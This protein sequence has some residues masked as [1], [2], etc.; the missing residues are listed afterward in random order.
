MSNTDEQQKAFEE[1]QA[2]QNRTNKIHDSVKMQ[3][4]RL[5]TSAPIMIPQGYAIAGG[6]ALVAMIVATFPIL[7]MGV[8]LG[9]FIAIKLTNMSK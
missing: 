9:A 8:A 1:F 3:K 7:L 4:K 5:D 2:W 6:I